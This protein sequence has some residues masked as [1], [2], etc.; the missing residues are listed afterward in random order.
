MIGED[1]Q[2]RKASSHAERT[3]PIALKVEQWRTLCFM[4]CWQRGQS[5]PGSLMPALCFITLRSCL[6]EVG[7][8]VILARCVARGS[9]TRGEGVKLRDAELV[10]FRRMGLKGNSRAL[11]K[12]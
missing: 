9:T 7:A 6:V 11:C 3:K 8:A 1:G 12:G 2:A 4:K 5:L 10:M